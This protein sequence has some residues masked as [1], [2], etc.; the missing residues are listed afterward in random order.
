MRIWSIHPKY[1]DAKGLTALWRES[2]LARKVLENKTRGYKNHPQLFR[3]RNQKNPVAV[4]N[5]YLLFVF[6]EA[7]RRN[8]SF[9]KNKI[10]QNLS[11]ERISVTQGQI[12]YE[13]AHLKKKLKV[14]D[15]KKLTEIASVKRFHPH[16]L[17]RI[18]K[19]NIEHW[20]KLP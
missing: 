2:L 1:L 4:I 19:G 9:D 7:K 16:P 18:E 14:R 5:K 11:A 3:F 8:Y 15:R 20:E 13:I 6:E 10:G 12:K 17:F